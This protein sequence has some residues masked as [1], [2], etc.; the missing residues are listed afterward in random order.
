VHLGIYLTPTDLE[1]PQSLRDYARAAEDLGFESIFVPQ[2]THIPVVEETEFPFGGPIPEAYQHLLDPFVYLSHVAALTSRLRVGTGICLALQNDPIVLAKQV[3]SL[4]L[5][6]GGRFV[7]GV[8]AGWNVPEMRNHGVEPATRWEALGER[9]E[10]LRVIWSRE[11]ASFAGEHLAFTAMRQWPKPTQVPHPPVLVG[12]SQARAR[13]L[14]VR[15]GT[16]WMPNAGHLGEDVLAAA[17]EEVR[18]AAREGGG[19]PTPV[20]IFRA[21]P[22]PRLLERWCALGV[23]RCVFALPGDSFATDL[24][25]MRRW[26]TL[27]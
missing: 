9:I 15:L 25:R 2:H 27:T 18:A 1:G 10:A 16:G 5:L 22:R 14:A 6:S 23:E 12:G 19:T 21:T 11:H 4:D 13:D 20:T 7:F 24:E 26:S 8:G 17:I 3:A